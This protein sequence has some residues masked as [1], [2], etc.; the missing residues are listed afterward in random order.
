MDWN[1]LRKIRVE[2]SAWIF[3]SVLLLLLPL[4]WVMASLAAAAFHE[5]CH[6]LALRFCAI[7]IYGIRIGGRGA[8][9]E[10]GPVSVMEEFICALAGPLGSIFLSLFIHTFPRIGICGLV[11]GLYNLLPFRLMDGGRILRCVIGLLHG[12]SP[13][14]HKKVGVQ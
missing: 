6:I 8:T 4:N 9:L 3:F 7:P 13:C 5:C 10:T 2:A 11:Q 1:M 12:K 14:K